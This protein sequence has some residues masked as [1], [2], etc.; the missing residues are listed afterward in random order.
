M[1]R[2]IMNRSTNQFAGNSLFSSERILNS[3]DCLWTLSVHLNS[4]VMSENKYS[5]KFS[6][7][8]EASVYL[9]LFSVAY[10]VASFSRF[11]KNERMI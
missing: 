1:K 5:S 10:K 8:I 2:H 7:Q 4:Q 11:S 3:D 6:R 9:E